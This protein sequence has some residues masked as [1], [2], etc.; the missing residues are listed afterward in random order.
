MNGYEDCPNVL[1]QMT[2]GMTYGASASA[3]LPLI[4]AASA[5]QAPF[6]ELFTLL[7]GWWQSTCQSIAKLEGQK[8]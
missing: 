1:L 3:V 7:G 4:A 5:G 2:P 6:G 8:R